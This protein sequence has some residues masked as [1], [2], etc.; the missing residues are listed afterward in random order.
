MLRKIAAY[1]LKNSAFTIDRAGSG[2][3]N[4]RIGGVSA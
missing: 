1:S 3:L 2:N 4:R